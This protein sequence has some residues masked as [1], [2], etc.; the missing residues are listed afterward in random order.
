MMVVL[1]PNACFWKNVGQ[2]A[3]ECVPPEAARSPPSPTLCVKCLVDDM[4]FGRATGRGASGDT[5]D[6]P[7]ARTRW[8]NDQQFLEITHSD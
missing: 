8:Q 2:N 4:P 6:P 5:G 7:G 1:R 3:N